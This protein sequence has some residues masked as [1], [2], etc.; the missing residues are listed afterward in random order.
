[1]LQ[2]STNVEVM[3]ADKLS[4]VDIE[5]DRLRQE[6]NR[7]HLENEHLQRMLKMAPPVP[8]DSSFQDKGHQNPQDPLHSVSKDSAMHIRWKSL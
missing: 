6:N 3:H 7:L 1:M 4:K 5:I 2:R 8:N